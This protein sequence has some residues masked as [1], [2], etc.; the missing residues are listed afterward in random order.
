MQFLPFFLNFPIEA[1][2]PQTLSFQ[3][4]YSSA[5]LLNTHI[6]TALAFP[7]KSLYINSLRTVLTTIPEENPNEDLFMF[8]HFITLYAWNLNS[9][10]RR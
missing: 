1:V 8:V 10:N 5:Q 4:E 6:L 3:T 2:W 9:A 7:F